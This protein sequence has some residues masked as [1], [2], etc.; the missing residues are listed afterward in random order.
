VGSDNLNRRS[1]QAATTAPNPWH[2]AEPAR[3]VGGPRRCQAARRSAASRLTV[4]PNLT[5]PGLYY[6]VAV[7]SRDVP[8]AARIVKIT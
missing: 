2:A 1:H 4:R 8:S 6:L 3:L 7:D 5:P